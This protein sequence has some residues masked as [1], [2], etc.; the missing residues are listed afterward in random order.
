MCDTKKRYDNI[1]QFPGAYLKVGRHESIVNH[2][3]NV[4]VLL[5]HVHRRSDISDFHRRV[6]WSFYPHHLKHAHRVSA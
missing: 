5:D 2:N 4:A 1:W 6:G 3:D